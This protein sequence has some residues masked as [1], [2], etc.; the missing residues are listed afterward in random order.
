MINA[1]ES[2]AEIDESTQDCSGGFAALVEVLEDEIQHL[3]QIVVNGATRKS[4]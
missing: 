2:F 3:N 1:I 4:P